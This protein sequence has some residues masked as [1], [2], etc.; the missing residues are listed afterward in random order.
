MS[1][2]EDLSAEIVELASALDA[3]TTR[4]ADLPTEGDVTQD[5]LDSLRTAITR[6]NDLAQAAPE[7]PTDGGGATPVDPSTPVTGDDGDLPVGS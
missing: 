2:T 1:N 5:Q 7:V 4:V 6:V 3:L